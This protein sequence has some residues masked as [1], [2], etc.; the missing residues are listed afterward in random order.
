MPQGAGCVG[1]LSTWGNTM[2]W[3]PQNWAIG[4]RP[5]STACDGRLRRSGSIRVCYKASTETI[6]T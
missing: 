2:T 4:W 6:A 5:T 1:R 3:N